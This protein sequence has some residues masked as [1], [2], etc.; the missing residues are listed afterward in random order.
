M[1]EQGEGIINDLL[2]QGLNPLISGLS[3][4]EKRKES[5]ALF[6]FPHIVYDV[7]NVGLCEQLNTEVKD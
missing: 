4:S 5:H 2:N 3:F 7:L 6:S 1:I